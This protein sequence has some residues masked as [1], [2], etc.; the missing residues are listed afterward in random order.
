MSSIRRQKGLF[1]Y[2][3]QQPVRPFY[4]R[5]DDVLSPYRGL[6]AQYLGCLSLLLHRL[7]KLPSTGQSLPNHKI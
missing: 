2:F 3:K 6:K 4:I 7:L 1:I 5:A